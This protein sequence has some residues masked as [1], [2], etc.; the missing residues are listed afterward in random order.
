MPFRNA[1]STV[2]AYMLVRANLSLLSSFE[3]P[4]SSTQRLAYAQSCY[5]MH[6]VTALS[7]VE[8]KKSP[9]VCC[10]AAFLGRY[11][12]REF[13]VRCPG[14]RPENCSNSWRGH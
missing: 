2:Q 9:D 7:H 8:K 12:A 1:E 6:G 11:S 3:A 4:G 5:L 14:A 13:P 10:T